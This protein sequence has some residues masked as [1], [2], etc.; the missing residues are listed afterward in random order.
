MKVTSEQIKEFI[1][2]NLEID[3]KYETSFGPEL[4]QIISLKFKGDDRAFT[5]SIVTVP[6]HKEGW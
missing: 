1:R 2:E 3:V 6:S 5:E 4:N